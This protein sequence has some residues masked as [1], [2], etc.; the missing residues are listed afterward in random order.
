MP[1]HNHRRDGPACQHPLQ[2]R[3][4]AQKRPL[5]EQSTQTA[6]NTPAVYVPSQPQALVP[7][8]KSRGADASNKPTHNSS[9]MSGDDLAVALP[10][11]G[12]RSVT[13]CSRGISYQNNSL[14]SL[15][16]P[17]TE[18]EFDQP[19]FGPLAVAHPSYVLDSSANSKCN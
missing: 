2:N 12:E 11:T 17:K 3:A 19:G 4:P 5:F 7:S 1:S 8:R 14:I 9:L 6:T 15:A 13:R 16:D 10:H 18:P